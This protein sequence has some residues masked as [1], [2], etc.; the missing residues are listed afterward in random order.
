MMI[1]AR[2]SS[3]ILGNKSHINVYEQGG[4]STIGNVF[5]R[6]VDNLSDGSM[7]IN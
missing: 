4:M 7:D 2:G 5:P 3:V 1:H 6:V